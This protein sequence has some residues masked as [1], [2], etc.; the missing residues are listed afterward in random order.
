MA[1]PGDLPSQAAGGGHGTWHATGGPLRHG[2]ALG[3]L[4]DRP[5]RPGWM[6]NGFGREFSTQHGDLI[7]KNGDL[8]IKNI[9]LSLI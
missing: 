2:G 6:G 5:G 1:I 3:I 4:L 9:D 7:I 8:T